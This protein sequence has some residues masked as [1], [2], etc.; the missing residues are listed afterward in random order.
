MPKNIKVVDFSP[1]QIEEML[2]EN[3]ADTSKEDAQAEALAQAILQM[4]PDEIA[5]YLYESLVQTNV[6]IEA[7]NITDE[8]SYHDAIFIAALN[9]SRVGLDAAISWIENHF[10]LEE[11][12]ADVES[13]KNKTKTPEIQKQ[14]K[15]I[16]YGSENKSAED[17]SE[18]L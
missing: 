13:N 12:Q 4:E 16:V 18:Q 6:L 3:L 7:A 15:R 11:V 1:E 14:G 17:D 5:D 9:R 8:I 2:G 10:S